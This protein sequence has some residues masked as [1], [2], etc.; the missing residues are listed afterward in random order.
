MSALKELQP[1]VELVVRKVIEVLNANA[2]TGIKDPDAIVRRLN[3]AI[4]VLESSA[5]LIE[6]RLKP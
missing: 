4:T 5:R 2:I 3:L 6:A 1:Q